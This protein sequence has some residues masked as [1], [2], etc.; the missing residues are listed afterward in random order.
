MAIERGLMA[1]PAPPTPEPEP[2]PTGQPE[3]I[4]PV[5]P[6]PTAP[7]PAAPAAEVPPE[8]VAQ[9]EPEP[10]M[11][12]AS[13]IAPPPQ[14]LAAPAMSL[15]ERLGTQWA[16]WVGGIALALGGIF[17]V[18]YSIE[19]GLDRAEGAD[20][21]RRAV[22]ARADR[23]GRMGAAVGTAR[24]HFRPAERAHS[25]HPHRRRHG[26]RL[27]RRLR[28]LLCSTNS[29]RRVPHSSCSASWRS[30]RSRPRC[31]MGRRWPGS[32]LSA[33]MSRRC[34]SRPA[35]RTTGRSTSISRW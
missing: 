23:R 4:S 14:A 30:R 22:R 16:V 24:R 8:P 34:W 7:A 12:A 17:L 13:P 26:G 21:P 28:R 29:S 3:P 35:S 15:E 2:I 18:R 20:H 9:P 33:P 11:A 27:C 1:A 31:C 25:E 6:E 5:A 19:A 32:G 10:A